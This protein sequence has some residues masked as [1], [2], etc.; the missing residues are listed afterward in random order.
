MKI[1]VEFM[2]C[3]AHSDDWCELNITPEE[4]FEPTED[5]EPLDFHSVPQHTDLRNY[6]RCESIRAIRVT[7]RGG[8]ENV[9]T[10]SNQYWSGDSQFGETISTG[11]VKYHRL[12]YATQIDGSPRRML[13]T[14]LEHRDGMFQVVSEMILQTDP[15][16]IQVWRNPWLANGDLLRE[17]EET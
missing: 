8:P 14:N 9:W 4:F 13:L 1:S 10:T 16:S 15:E 3:L 11:S 2:Y 7:I 12:S 5:G 6:L 17:K